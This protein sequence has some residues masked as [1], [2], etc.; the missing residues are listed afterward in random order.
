MAACPRCGELTASGQEY[1]VECGLRLP[2]PGP[3]GASSAAGR[4]WVKRAL[5]AFVVAA[6]G[7]A[8]AV[9]AAGGGNGGTTDVLTATGG[10][11]SVPTSNT[12]AAPGQV[13]ARG[14]GAWPLARSGWTIALASLPQTQGRKPAVAQVRRARKAGLPNVGILDSSAYASLHPGYWI[15]FAGVY[16][17]QAEA[18]SALQGA[19]EFTRSASVRNVVP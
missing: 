12:V 2:G 7:A 8:A 14:V 4:G 9:A 16:T 5:L 1:C 6:A 19:R 3:V 15:V 11:A 18:T 17:S 13:G 10:F